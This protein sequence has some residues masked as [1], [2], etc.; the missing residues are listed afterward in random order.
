MVFTFLDKDSHFQVLPLMFHYLYCRQCALFSCSLEI[1]RKYTA[2]NLSKN[3]NNLL[4]EKS[5]MLFLLC[6]SR[7]GTMFLLHWK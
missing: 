4:A 6:V 5:A 1:S 7:H 3:L 2:I